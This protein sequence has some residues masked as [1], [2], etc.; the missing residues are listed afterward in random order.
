MEET[1]SIQDGRIRIVVLELIGLKEKSRVLISIAGDGNTQKL[2][3]QFGV[4]IG[5]GIKGIQ[6]DN[7]LGNFLN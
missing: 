2:E 4:I 6:L 1:N 3:G 7:C 5:F